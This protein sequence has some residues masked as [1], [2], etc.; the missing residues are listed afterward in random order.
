MQKEYFLSHE[1]YTNHMQAWKK[2]AASS[3]IRPADVVIHNILRS[4]PATRGFCAKRKNI[5]G[6]NAW[7]SF[8][9]AKSAARFMCWSLNEPR[10]IE[11]LAKFTVR[12]GIECPEGFE[13]LIMEQKHE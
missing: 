13:K 6:N 11:R 2:I 7:Y 8:E 10:R 12:Y 4:L 5:Q 1:Q 9:E 3:D